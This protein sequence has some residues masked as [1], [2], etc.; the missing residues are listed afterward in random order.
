MIDTAKSILQKYKGQ[1]IAIATSGGVDSMTLCTLVLSCGLF[2]D[3]ALL[4]VDHNLR[5]TS[6]RDYELVKKFAATRSL[7]F[8]SISADVEALAKKNKRSIEHE[9]REIRYKFFVEFSKK[10][11]ALIMLGHTLDDN[12]ETILMHIFRGCGLNGLVGMSEVSDY[13]CK[14]IRPL[15]ATTKQEIYEYAKTNNV[16][17]NEDETNSDIKH[18]RNLV[19]RVMDEVAVHYP[20]VNENVAKLGEVANKALYIT[21]SQLNEEYF[22]SEKGAV[23]LSKKIK[24]MPL[25]NYYIIEAA[26]RVGLVSNFENKHVVAILGLENGKRLNL[27]NGFGLHSDKEHWAFVK[28]AGDDV[29]IAAYDKSQPVLYADGDKLEGAVFRFRRE[30]D[31]FRKFG[32]KTKKLKDFFNEKGMPSRLR[33][34]VP[35]LVKEDKI[36]VVIG[37]EIADEVKVT[38]ETKKVVRLWRE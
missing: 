38:K 30:G 17:F 18:A 33:D 34:S 8:E 5:E 15:I 7:K 31:K 26:K 11:G 36:L 27:P 32:G 1:S 22:K 16:E 13:P 23:Y 2:D 35:L 37:H 24:G 14:I 25:E 29:H 19:R 10:T 21:Q 20:S 28:G 4:H 6:K 3:I 12:A 9:A